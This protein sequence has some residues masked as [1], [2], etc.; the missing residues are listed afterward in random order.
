MS[1]FV[2]KPVEPRA[3]FATLLR[4][5]GGGAVPPPLPPTAHEPPAVPPQRITSSTAPLLPGIEVGVGLSHTLGKWSLYRRLL[6]MF[7]E[8]HGPDYVTAFRSALA[9]GDRTTAQRIA[10]TLKGVA[11][12]LGAVELSRTAAAVEAALRAGEAERARVD[13]EAIVA[14]LETV[15][16]G[17]VDIGEVDEAGPAPE[18]PASR[19]EQVRI[20]ANLMAL[21]ESRDTAAVDC[22]EAFARA[23]GRD[24]MQSASIKQLKGAVNRYDY[25]RAIELLRQLT[26]TACTP[27]ENPT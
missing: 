15:M 14:E 24:G 2:A 20:A 10:H 25:G 13:A 8:E 22:V 12:T 3:F 11:A 16:Q 19:D 18:Q 17:L 5:L 4:W 26:E 27:S 23:L 21:L 9:D 1:G 6:V 7:R